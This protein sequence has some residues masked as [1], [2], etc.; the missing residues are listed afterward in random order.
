M[1]IESLHVAADN[2]GRTEV[3][4]SAILQYTILTIAEHMEEM[5][6]EYV[7]LFTDNLL[8]LWSKRNGSYR[9]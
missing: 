6:D 2:P 1:S 4:C 8:E 9:V 7:R 3:V 5:G